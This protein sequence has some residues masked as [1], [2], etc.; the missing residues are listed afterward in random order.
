[1]ETTVMNVRAP[2][3][4]PTSAP[5]ILAVLAALFGAFLILMSICGM[6]AYLILPLAR[7]RNALENNT[8]LASVCAIGL[9]F[10]AII[11]VVSFAVIRGKSLPRLILPSPWL[12]LGFFLIVVGIGQ[13]IL[14]ARVGAEYLF[15]PWHVLA[16]LMLPL[17]A[18]A[19]AS[20]RLSPVP[21]QGV[22]AQM[23]WGGAGSVML[24]LVFE[25]VAG[26][27]LFLAA[28]LVL[29]A[30]LGPDQL[31]QLFGQ[32]GSFA[33]GSPDVERIMAALSRQPVVLFV[34]IAA[35]LAFFTVIGPLIEETLKGLGPGIWIVRTRPSASRALLWGLAAGAGFAFSENL[36]LGA[37]LVSEQGGGGGLWGALILARA[38]TS[39]VHVA[40]TG[41]VSL[42]WYS[43]F[44]GGKR[45]SFVWFFIAGF[46]AHGSWNLLTLIL[47]SVLSTGGSFSFSSGVA[48][49]IGAAIAALAL[50][51]FILLVLAAALWI[52]WLIRWAK[53]RD[54]T[55]MT[56]PI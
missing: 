22:L 26:V 33:N 23:A 56:E 8:V 39:L 18:L 17:A 15:P 52:A 29:A 37:N 47:S 50:V 45:T 42:G 48:G 54:Q 3:E 49:A 27:F 40:A 9:F 11:L 34:A 10:G 44:V 21:G 24:A 4:A 38:G 5:H 51:V 2:T 1:M 6:L 25:L 55:E 43:A 53:R 7:P 19:Y 36:L 41:T 31:T 16:S 12:F 32:F 35:A 28:G 13:A 20:R 14:L 46:G 30:L